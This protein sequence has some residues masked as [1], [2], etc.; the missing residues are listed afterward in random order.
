MNDSV[1]QKDIY[2]YISSGNGNL[3]ISAKAGSGKTT[4]IIKSLDYLNKKDKVLFI[5]FNKSIVSE[6]KERI[7]NPNVKIFTLHGL[8]YTIICNNNEGK[9]IIIDEFKYKHYINDVLS[10]NVLTCD[11]TP[12]QYESYVNNIL[13]LVDLGRM[14]MCYNVN[15]IEEVANKYSIDVINDECK[16]AMDA[17]WWG[18]DT[19]TVIDFTDMIYLPIILRYKPLKYD[20]IYLDEA[21]DANIAQRELMLKCIK[22]GGRFIAVGDEKQCI[23]GFAGSSEDSFNVL[24]NLPYTK[25][26]PLSVCYRCSKNIIRFVNKIEKNIT[27]APNA[28]EGE[29]NFNCMISDIK[30]NDMVICRNT[31]PLTVLYNKLL[32]LGKRVSIKGVDIGHNLINLIQQTGAEQII[33]T[34]ECDGLIDRLKTKLENLI[35][36]LSVKHNLVESEANEL[37]KVS[38]LR[39]KI[40][41]IQV[42]ALDLNTVDE[43][44]LKIESI[45]SDESN[46]IILTT[47]HKSKGL[48]SDN[49]YILAPELMPSKSAKTEV[50]KQQEINLMYV[51]FTRPKNKLGFIK[52]G[53]VEY[54]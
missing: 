25:T 28:K 4:T 23:Y 16:I 38:I 13:K 51:A 9:K 52:K 26:L 12:K 42:L 50:E 43:L 2:K 39:D 7:K 41:S 17:I 5:A 20:V 37:N 45:F 19:P 53:E 32:L 33:S 29:V 14:Y 31:Y 3:V 8:G 27:Y 54:K 46:G 47:I 35:K 49:V 40:N 44:I 24:S 48:E 11:L 30:D 15:G 36:D 21:Q 1:F 10:E 34:K 22:Q 6:L 18:E